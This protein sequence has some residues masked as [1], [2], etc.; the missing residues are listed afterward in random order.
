M[1][2]GATSLVCVK[3]DADWSNGTP[4]GPL[5]WHP[6]GPNVAHDVALGVTIVMADP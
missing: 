2:P 1:T 5:M 4:V 6:E 3:F